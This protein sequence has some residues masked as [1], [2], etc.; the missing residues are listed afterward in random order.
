LP[1]ASNDLPLFA[2]A[3]EPEPAPDPLAAALAA[4]E[5][6]SLTPREALEE[7]YRPQATDRRARLMQPPASSWSR[8]GAHHRPPGSPSGSPAAA[9][10]ARDSRIL[11]SA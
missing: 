3:A 5:P 8:I 7:L 9:A 1:P 6:D 11:R 10:Q 2:T 4:I